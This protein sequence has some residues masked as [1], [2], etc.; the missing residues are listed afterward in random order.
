MHLTTGL[1]PLWFF[2]PGER[3]ISDSSLTISWLP[4]DL[5]E[6]RWEFFNHPAK[7]EWY[8][9]HGVSWEQINSHFRTGRLAPYPRSERIGEIL[10]SN[11]Y[12][13]Y[14]DYLVYLARAKRGY[15]KN[16]TLMENELQN[17]GHLVLKAAIVLSSKDDG[18]LFSGYR[19]LC[20][21]WNYGMI[22]YI[23]LVELPEYAESRSVVSS[24]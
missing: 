20:L 23:W 8:R 13:R 24:T 7:Q 5:E 4:P 3:V 12:H 1:L 2:I 11:S 10:I 17:K 19:R 9:H 6:E 22:P 15:R 16:Y 18:L 21:A 14:L